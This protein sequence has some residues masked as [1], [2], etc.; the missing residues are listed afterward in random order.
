MDRLHPG[1]SSLPSFDTEKVTFSPMPIVRTLR[2][3]GEA[4]V[5]FLPGKGITE[6]NPYFPERT[7]NTACPSSMRRNSRPETSFAG[8]PPTVTHSMERAGTWIV[9]EVLGG[10]MT[11]QSNLLPSKV[12]EDEASP[13]GVS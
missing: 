1:M 7:L 8:R 4:S 10:T 2:P 11:V 6:E 13:Y 5:T 9:A 3:S 12:H